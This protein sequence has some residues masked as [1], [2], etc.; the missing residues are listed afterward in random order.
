MESCSFLRL[1]AELVLHILSHLEPFDLVKTAQTCRTLQQHS[2]DDFLWLPLV[3]RNIVGSPVDGTSFPSYRELYAAH[4]P[5]WF[6]PRH[7]IWFSDSSPSGKLL[8]ARYEPNAGRI[9]AYTVTAAR[10]PHTLQSWEKNRSVIIHHFNPEVSLD[11]TR[12]V[13]NLA[14]H[15][16]NREAETSDEQPS[17]QRPAPSSKYGK[18]V[19]M[20]NFTEQG[21]YAAFML[22]RALP[23]EAITESTHV[24]PPLRIPAQA[25]TR[26]VSGDDFRSAGH[27]PTTFDEISQYNFRVRKWVEFG[28]RGSHP[29]VSPAHAFNTPDG[30]AAALG[31]VHPFFAARFNAY[32]PSGVSVRIPEEIT[33]YATLPPSCYTP[34]P[35]KPY[36][37]IWCGD[38]SGHGCEFLVITQ[39]DKEQAR[40]L[41]EGMAWLR[42]WF[43]GRDAGPLG[44]ANRYANTDVDVDIL[45]GVDEEEIEEEESSG[46]EKTRFPMDNTLDHT[47]AGSSSRAAVE[48]TDHPD[49]PSGRLEAIKLT[50]DPYIPR[51][52]FT[53]VAPDIG[54][55]GFIR[56]AD[57]QAFRGARVV[58]SAGHVAD[59]D[60]ELDQYTPSQ[61][62]LLSHNT[63]AQ[64]WERMGHISYYQRVDLDAL[65]NTHTFSSSRNMNLRNGGGETIT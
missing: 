30:F 60:F 37:G 49:A 34:T 33:T 35:A 59:R 41:P 4:H 3:Q 9:A 31:R 58:R 44:S 64:F 61:L 45:G 57:E 48:V 27:R 42:N 32:S 54:A 43:A 14:P 8:V 18:E 36:Q 6:L 20:D 15:K 28:T 40:P 19:L 1:P 21:L 55:G 26:N 12:P 25:R 16:A 52:E 51:G 22:C 7:R 53:F 63:L 46:D 24:W 62:I 38:Y 39:P 47:T 13:L 5:H 17:G 10:G 65:A 23:E 29:A 11:L 2:Y 50:G 56:I